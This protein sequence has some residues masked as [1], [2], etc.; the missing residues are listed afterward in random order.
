MQRDADEFISNN[1]RDFIIKV[2]IINVFINGRAAAAEVQQQQQWQQPA[3]S[4]LNK[5]LLW[6]QAIKEEVRIDGRS[7]Y[8]CRKIHVQVYPLLLPIMGAARCLGVHPICS[9]P[10]RQMFVGCF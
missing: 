5:P 7:P 9:T 2:I 4:T 3:S 10:S 1:E 8:E 6:M